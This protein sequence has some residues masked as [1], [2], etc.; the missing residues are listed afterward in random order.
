[1]D[2]GQNTSAAAAGTLVVREYV[3]ASGNAAAATQTGSPQQITERARQARLHEEYEA[4]DETERSEALTTAATENWG[5]TE[6]RAVAGAVV[7]AGVA[8]GAGRWQLRAR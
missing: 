1:M 4:G 3:A 7:T 6:G 2:E 8:L 5:V